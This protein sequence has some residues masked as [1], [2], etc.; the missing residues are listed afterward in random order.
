MR[1]NINLRTCS[2]SS[3]TRHTLLPQVSLRIH[4]HKDD[5]NAVAWADDSGNL[6]LSGSDDRLCKVLPH[7]VHF[8]F[9]P[10]KMDDSSL[11]PKPRACRLA[12]LCVRR[13]SQ[14]S[15]LP[16]AQLQERRFRSGPSWCAAAL[17]FLEVRWR[18]T[19]WVT[20][21][22]PGT[23]AVGQ[24]DGGGGARRRRRQLH[25]AP[26]CDT[27]TS[28]SALARP[29]VCNTGLSPCATPLGMPR[30]C[31][32]RCA[33]AGKEEKKVHK[34]YMY[35]PCTSQL[36]GEVHLYVDQRCSDMQRG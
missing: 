24:A 9:H 31:D 22:A 21:G 3:A 6:L 12:L 35:Q 1:C 5:V 8:T 25:W 19:T 13:S 16:A 2:E 15:G 33:L 32:L 23:A 18:T 14:P 11:N 17:D 27:Y 10:R 28:G 36:P 29:R 26:G 7:L 34:I 30:T 4:G 20:P